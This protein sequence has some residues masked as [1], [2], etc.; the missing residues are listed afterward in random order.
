MRTDSM[1]EAQR[2]IRSPK[3]RDRSLVRGSTTST[4]TAWSP[5]LFRS[6]FETGASGI[7]RNLSES[8]AC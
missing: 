7:S 4:P 2:K 6:T 8:I 5:A 1:A 3:S